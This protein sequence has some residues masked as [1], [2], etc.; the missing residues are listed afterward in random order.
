MRAR[1]KKNKNLKPRVILEKID[2]FKTIN[3][4]GRVSYSPFEYEDAIAAL[5]SMVEFP[6]LDGELDRQAIVSRAVS[7]AAR[8]ESL[9]DNLVIEEVNAEIRS[10]LS[11]REEIYFVLTSLSLGEPY[12]AG[13]IIS[14]D[15]KIKLS[16]L[17]F[18]KKFF[19]RSESFKSW[20]GRKN[21][22][23]P[24][25]A[26]VVIQTNAK[27]EDSAVHKALRELD[28]QRAIWNLLCNSSI[29]LRFGG[30]AK[31]INKI[32]LGA[33]HTLHDEQGRSSDQFWYDPNF[34]IATPYV[35][36][37]V[38]KFAKDV[39]WINRRLK[40]HPYGYELKDA[41]LRFVR[42]F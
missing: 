3:P 35:H 16:S 1:W 20:E 14:G 40:S 18:P 25:Y 8:R 19:S 30:E 27:S 7:N 28:L 33:A 13:S 29:E 17:E 21:S 5:Q 12:P 11:K 4:D 10:A 41:L 15:C 36:K 38:A 24:G 37:D 22:D 9:T 2:S 31:P 32:R 39:R 23:P 6:S 42:A 34:V 26:R